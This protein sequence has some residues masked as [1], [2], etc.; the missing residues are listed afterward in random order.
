MVLLSNNS[1]FP[2]GLLTTLDISLVVTVVLELNHDGILM[3]LYKTHS[4]LNFHNFVLKFRI[5]L[6]HFAKTHD[7]DSQLLLDA[8][9][10]VSNLVP[11]TCFTSRGTCAT[12]CQA[13]I[14][15]VT[16][17]KMG[18]ILSTKTPTLYNENFTGFPFWSSNLNL[19]YHSRWDYSQD[20]QLKDLWLL[21]S[22]HFVQYLL[23]E[24]FLSFAFFMNCVIIEISS[25]AADF[26]KYDAI[27]WVL[28][29]VNCDSCPFSLKV[30]TTMN[31]KLWSYVVNSR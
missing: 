9:I 18:K 1:T 2:L 22:Q 8:F 5:V 24:S 17:F 19:V 25:K 16:I 23:N 11:P 26:S 20:T 29:I 10:G 21:V 28:C 31:G 6:S 7:F 27:H 15:Y 3:F 12:S 30:T 13:V 14:L 4:L